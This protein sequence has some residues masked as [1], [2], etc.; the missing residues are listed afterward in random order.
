M[1]SIC[2]TEP[3]NRIPSNLLEWTRSLKAWSNKRW[4]SCLKMET[5]NRRLKKNNDFKRFFLTVPIFNCDTGMNRKTNFNNMGKRF[6][7]DVCLIQRK[8]FSWRVS[9]PTSGAR[10]F[11]RPS[12]NTSKAC[13]FFSSLWNNHSETLLRNVSLRPASGDSSDTRDKRIRDM[14]N[15]FSPFD[16]FF[17]NINDWT[18]WKENRTNKN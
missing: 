8:F 12:G 13:R 9:H 10:H 16:Q 17:R 15:F 4:Q 2:K 18:N 1:D 14:P 7:H 3:D 11:E 6:F 5:K